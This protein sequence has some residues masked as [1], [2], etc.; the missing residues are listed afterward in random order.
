MRGIADLKRV[1]LRR[2]QTVLA[3]RRTDQE[4]TA[5]A[6][7]PPL[8]FAELFQ[9]APQEL[10][11]KG[12]PDLPRFRVSAADQLDRSN[13]FADARLKLRDAFTPSQPVADRRMFAGRIDVLRQMI[14]AIEDQ[15][16]HLVLYGERGIGKT[17]LLHVFSEAAKDARY[18]VVYASCGAESSFEETFRTAA[19]EIPLLYHKGFAPT[20]AEAEAGSTMAEILP[21]RLTPR[22]FADV[23]TKLTGTRVLL[24]LDEFDRATAPGF[25]RELAELIKILSDR[26]V[27]VQLVIAGVTA[28]LA[29]LVEHTPSIRRNILALRVPLMSNEEILQLVANGE[30]VSGVTFDAAARDLI[31]AVAH[32]LPYFA[33]LIANHAS[34]R[35]LDHNRPIVVADDVAHAIDQSL[36]ELHDRIPGAAQALVDRLLEQGLGDQ[37]STIAGAALGTGGVFGAQDLEE[38]AGRSGEAARCKRLAEQLATEDVILQIREE[39]QGRRYAFIEEGLPA[40]I[41]LFK[42]REKY[43]ARE[44][45][46]L[47]TA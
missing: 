40:Y 30:R 45:A 12:R 36:V 17:S 46:R 2:L 32:G 6:P 10:E 9:H 25:R 14:R 34:L 24:F 13:H 37:L 21:E 39:P 16:L 27:R 44:G 23:C 28:N 8:T 20:A 29:E 4:T 11:R 7:R 42:A 1:L 41:W 18:I 22:A 15:R 33:H 43:R 35:A 26:A 31:V 47:T 5:T 3:F 19:A 38:A